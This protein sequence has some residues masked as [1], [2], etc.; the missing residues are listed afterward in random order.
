M[1][2]RSRTFS[3][4]RGST[5]GRGASP[6]NEAPALANS[7]RASRSLS[8]GLSSA[9]VV[10]EGP[11]KKRSAKLH[12][13]SE[14]HFQLRGQVLQYHKPK[15]A[16]PA[17]CFLLQPGVVLTPVVE[18]KMRSM[19]PLY[20]FKICWPGAGKKEGEEVA[21][22]AEGKERDGIPPLSPSQTRSTHRRP[23]NQRQPQILSPSLESPSSEGRVTPTTPKSLARH[24]SVNLG[25]HV[26]TQRRLHD[27]GSALQEDG[28]ENETIRYLI[29]M[30]EEK[31]R[32]Q[33]LHKDRMNQQGDEVPGSKSSKKDSRLATGVKVGAAVATGAATV[34]A[35]TAGVGLI[36]GLVV[37]GLFSATT[38]AGGIGYLSYKD[39]RHYP[40]PLT[41]G[42]H[43]LEVAEEWRGKLEQQLQ[44]LQATA[45]R[46][47]TMSRRDSSAQGGVNAEA[48]SFPV[49]ASPATDLAAANTILR[50][51]RWVCTGMMHGARI[52]CDEDMAS[53]HPDGRA[54][55]ARG[56]RPWATKLPVRRIQATVH[57]SPLE[58][59]MAIMASSTTHLNGAH[60][61]MRIVETLDDHSDIIHLT[62]WPFWLDVTWVTPRDFCLARYWCLDSHGCYIVCLDSVEHK[63][64]PP[65][66]GYVRGSLHSLSTVAPL[67]GHNL[68]SFEGAE[69]L[70]TTCLS[71]DPK[72]WIWARWGFTHRYTLK[73]LMHVLDVRD[74]IE[75]ERFVAPVLEVGGVQGLEDDLLGD[76][77]A[78]EANEELSVLETRPTCLRSMW[79]EADASSFLVRGASYLTD[80]VKVRSGPPMF[81]LSAVDLFKVPGPVQHV[82]SYAHN[83]VQLARA[84]GERGFVWVWQIQVPG[85]PHYSFVCYWTPVD[86][87]CLKADTPFGR[88][89][90][91]VFFG[92]EDDLRDKRLKLIPRITEGNW[93]VKGACPPT[94]AILGTKLRQYHFRG[95]NYLETD[96][97]VSSSSFGASVTRLCMGYAKL[98]VVDLVWCLQGNTEEELPECILGGVRIRNLDVSNA[99]SL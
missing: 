5:D 54:G 37:V 80:K 6:E 57:S 51:T 35:L 92:E 82:A 47:Q 39:K 87:A 91:R 60:S 43:S 34:A 10:M 13:W 93:V 49:P 46:I 19:R 74:D 42:S 33:R 40:K 48:I 25:T 84:A 27:N 89:A 65:I 15:D 76:E 95:D 24:G 20:A 98:L 23:S 75:A 26:L 12:T 68:Y 58:T 99:E 69:C 56:S 66:A 45:A 70:L 64:C 14:R 52:F 32:M 41:I 97:D 16:S 8:L 22:I 71:V 18:V 36:A 67:P 77:V 11:L 31:M 90:Q 28:M 7:T 62:C 61:S 78:E 2:R 83:R 72:G 81:K 29:Q 86:D 53:H 50:K 1:H 17:A 30:E 73:L 9:P 4:M 85:P 79:G 88:L 55:A 94:P 96:V 3:E 44:Q 21:D 63:D 38:S 59:F